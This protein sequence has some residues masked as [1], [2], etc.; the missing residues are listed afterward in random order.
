MSTKPHYLAARSYEALGREFRASGVTDLQV[1]MMRVAD[2][3]AID[4]F[5]MI[6]EGT[7]PKGKPL[8]HASHV[9]DFDYG[10]HCYT[11]SDGNEMDGEGWKRHLRAGA[12][13]L[14][15]ASGGSLQVSRNRS[16]EFGPLRE[17]IIKSAK[18]GLSPHTVASRQI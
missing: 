7:T 3:M 17:I 9:G 2:P 18:T 6:Y 14:H 1:R 5:F 10:T 13:E 8:T 16:K 15:K 4:R 11:D 12:R